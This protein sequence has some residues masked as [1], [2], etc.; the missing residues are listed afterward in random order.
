MDQNADNMEA[1][2]GFQQVPVLQQNLAARLQ[3][4]QQVPLQ[5]GIPGGLQPPSSPYDEAE[6]DALA[7]IERIEREAASEKCSKEVQDK[8]VQRSCHVLALVFIFLLVFFLF[9]LSL[10]VF[11]ICICVFLLLPSF[12]QALEKEET[13]FFPPRTRHGRTRRPNG[14]PGQWTNRRWQ[15]R[16]A[17]SARSH[18]SW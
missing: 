7:E 10:R 3:Q 11:N 17:N 14:C 15:C 18:C 8:G 5:A 6:L 2:M 4:Q 12:R 1:E 9:N 16:Q 13:R